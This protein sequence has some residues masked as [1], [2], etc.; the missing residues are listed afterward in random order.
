MSKIYP[1]TIYHLDH[2]LLMELS[3]KKKESIDEGEQNAVGYYKKLMSNLPR[4]DI[5]IKEE[6]CNK[7][8]LMLE[9]I[10]EEKIDANACS[11]LRMENKV[12]S[13]LQLFKAGYYIKAAD[14]D[15]GTA[16]E[17]VKLTTNISKHWSINPDKKVSPAIITDKSTT[18]YDLIARFDEFF[19]KMPLGFIDC[20]KKGYADGLV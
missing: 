18:S 2:H 7:H 8:E 15:S 12:S 14:V 3:R 4:N 13:A 9:A 17:A 6:Y 16:N 11:R 19:L 10:K 20:Q 1:Y 5:S